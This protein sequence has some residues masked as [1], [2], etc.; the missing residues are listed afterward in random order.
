MGNSVLGR[1]RFFY[2][3]KNFKKPCDSDG[4][5][6]SDGDSGREVLVLRVME[7]ILKKWESGIGCS[8]FEIKRKRKS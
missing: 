4:S 5:D 2:K 7:T 1:L 6:D 3:W 8:D